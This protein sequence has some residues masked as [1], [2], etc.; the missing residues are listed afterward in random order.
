MGT[1][2]P[3]FVVVPLMAQGHMVP[4]A[5]LALL[6]ASRGCRVS[7]IT[8]PVNA[9][10]LRATAELAADTGLSLRLVELP[11]PCADAGLPDGCENIDLF[12]DVDLN[13]PFFRALNLLA[14][15]LKR[16]L[17]A[18]PPGPTCIVADQCMPWTMEV[19]GELGIPRFVFHGPSCFFLLCTLKLTQHNFYEG[20]TDDR[21]T[22]F[23]V[24]ELP[25]SVGRIEVRRSTAQRFFDWP[26]LEEMRRHVEQGEA[27][28]DGHVLN[29]FEELEPWCLEEYRKALGRTV[30]SVGPVSGF[31]KTTRGKAARGGGADNG[32]GV[33]EWLE[34]RDK[35]QGTVIFVSFG[36]LMLTRMRQMVEIGHG[37]EAAGRAFIW[38]VKPAEKSEE[39]ERWLS[40][41]EKRTEGRGL[42]I[43]G[44]APQALIL[45][46][47]AV[48]GFVTHCGW[49]STV[50][51]VEAGVVMATWP[52]LV[53]QFL[54]ETLVVEVLGIGVRVGVK[55]P[56]YHLWGEE[57]VVLV[58]R[59][60]VRT[61]V[62]RVMDGGKE[63]DERRRRAAELGAKARKAME[64]GG[65][66][67]DNLNCLIEHATKLAAIKNF[68]M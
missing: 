60:M 38:A 46:H 27:V 24:P 53:D 26:G 19:A 64:E 57:E 29:T 30:W 56:A 45:N 5:D 31:H 12:M 3:H 62:E 68:S 13:V 40:E 11:F 44:W 41:F 33:K 28:A 67:F 34:S 6:L 7:L 18:E 35:R 51:A 23:T 32:S 61:A 2:K 54:N 16:Y 9:R 15:P 17:R 37:L 66:S 10:R 55:S 8:T 36:S 43:R 4:M 52:H 14:E 20:A 42:V 65:S 21:E 47:A 48:A 1:V 49:N 58:G 59:E 63:G 39:G 50:E 22:S 25:E